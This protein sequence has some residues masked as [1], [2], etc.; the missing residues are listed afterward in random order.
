M[1][2]G[3]AIRYL[4]KALEIDPN[5]KFALTLKGDAKRIHVKKFTE[6]APCMLINRFNTFHS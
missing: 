3:Q 5:N 6:I 1:D 4:D 2:F